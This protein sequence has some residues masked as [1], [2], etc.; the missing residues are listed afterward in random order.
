MRRRGYRGWAAASTAAITLSLLFLVVE[1]HVRSPAVT[2]AE[3]KQT[4]PVLSEYNPSTTTE[5]PG[6]LLTVDPGVA[7]S[8]AKYPAAVETGIERDVIQEPTKPA[9]IVKRPPEPVANVVLFEPIA[10]Y[11]LT[12]MPLSTSRSGIAYLMDAMDTAFEKPTRVVSAHRQTRDAPKFALNTNFPEIP[13]PATVQRKMPEPTS[14]ISGLTELQKLVDPR[15]GTP[16]KRF[17]YTR[18]LETPK[19]QFAKAINQWIVDSLQLL[20]SITFEYGLEN[21]KSVEAIQQLSSLAGQAPSIANQ[22]T[23]YRVAA[24]V[25]RLAY[26]IQRRVDVWT[27]IQQS[28]DGTTIALAKPR[29]PSHAREQLATSLQAVE[30][31]LGASPDGEAW[32]NFLMIEQLKNWAEQSEIDWNATDQLVQTAIKRLHWPTLSYQQKQFLAQD[33]FRNFAANLVVWGRDPVDYRQLL[34]EL[35]EL[36]QDSTSRIASSLAGSV[37]ALSLSEGRAQQFVARTLDTH[38]RNA[39]MRLSISAKLLE[40]FLPHGEYE[41]RPVRQ[42]ILGADTRGN[43]AVQTQLQLN[44]IP[45][46]NAWNVDVGVVGDMLTDTR[47]SKGPAVFHSTSTAQIDSHRYIRIAKEGY[48]VSSQPTAVRSRDYLKKMSTDYDGLPVIGDF[49]RLLVREQFDQKRGLAQKISR[50]LIAREADV[51]FDRRIDEAMEK[52]EDSLE[53]YLVG[54]LEKLKLNPT[55]ASLSTSKERLTVRYR[56]AHESQMAAF[57]PRPRA[58][59]DSLLSMQLHQSSINNAIAQLGLSDKTWEIGELYE[60]LGNIFQQSDW[61]LPDDVPED[62]SIRF[63][64]TRPATIELEDGKLRLTLRIAELS[65]PSRNLKIERFYVHSNYIPIASGLKAELIRD[66]VVE[67]VSNRSRLALR[68]IFAKVFVS[69]P[70]IPLTNAEWAKDERAGGLAVSQLDI[71]D[72]WLAVAVSDDESELAAEVA[73]RA[74]LEKMR[75]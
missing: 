6:I 31:T 47:S 21:Q 74:E 61:T 68:L 2:Q 19:P 12:D 58:P 25:L 36:E 34:V 49:V 51:E 73:N 42:R 54:P 17:V 9:E 14:L 66:G 33:E 45:D 52:A 28:L 69:Q 16:D 75:R 5:A 11:E 3:R 44:L 65:Q 48:A 62:I 26:A 67:I 32:R 13:A 15:F 55:V 56:V 64:Q 24:E 23:D 41:V 72:G 63:A 20:H 4:L 70:Q 53:Q 43:S 35:E 1:K 29:S 10:D 18:S 37:Q 39:N 8:I 60:H 22:L 46:P 27:A 57:T 50:R 30:D 40:R 7:D 38:Y 59:S 71:R